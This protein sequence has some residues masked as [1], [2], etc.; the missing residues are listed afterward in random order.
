MEDVTIPVG[1]EAIVEW[2]TKQVETEIKR[3]CP[4]C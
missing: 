4:E 2:I 1:M 3:Q